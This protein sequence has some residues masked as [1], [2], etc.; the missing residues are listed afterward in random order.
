MDALF[1]LLIV[2]GIIGIVVPFVPGS[3]LVLGAILGWAV[4]E[5]NTTGWLVAAIALV[6]IGLA[7]I[8]RLTIPEQRM[9]ASGV[10]RSSILVGFALGVVGFFVVPVVGLPL[11]FVLGVYLVE[12]ARVGAHAHAWAA[13]V[14][15]IR[16]IGLSIFIEVAGAMFASRSG[17]QAAT[18]RSIVLAWVLTVPASVTRP[19]ST[20][21]EVRSPMVLRLSPRSLVSVA[22]EVG[23]V[24]WTRVSRR[25]MLLRLSCSGRRVPRG[26]T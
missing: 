12:R 14:A 19:R 6:S 5:N 2:V 4:V 17:L 22:R 23:P 13:T 11:G 21:D 8:L 24:R 10:P 15:A 9:R 16:G 20:S 26:G 18:L 3:L 1:G 25:P 7:T